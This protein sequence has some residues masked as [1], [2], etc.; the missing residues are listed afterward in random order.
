MSALLDVYIKKE[1]LETLLKTVNTKGEKGVAI[2]ITNND[3]TNQYEQNVSSWVS[4]TK[5]QRDAKKERFFVGN[6]KCFHVKGE[7][8]TAK[9]KENK[10]QPKEAVPTPVEVDESELP[11]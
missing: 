9:R 6:G 5:E 8:K 11:F 2:T 1:T 4:Q 7:V 3:E 10:A